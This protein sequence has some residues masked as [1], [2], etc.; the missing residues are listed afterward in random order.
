MA[1]P[2]F[3]SSPSKDLARSDSTP[4]PSQTTGGESPTTLPRTRSTR[5][6]Q[7]SN[8]DTLTVMSRSVS[9]RTSFHHQQQAE[10]SADE[11]TPIVS[12]ER[13][14][15]KNKNYDATSTG[16]SGV[17][18]EAHTS[19]QSSSSSARRRKARPGSS[20]RDNPSG[21]EGKK[22]GGWGWNDLVEKYGSVELENKGSVARDH[23]ALGSSR[24]FLSVFQKGPLS[25]CP[26]IPGQSLGGLKH[27]D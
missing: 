14:G 5:S 13:G 15:A 27:T 8:P 7:F 11:I 22:G 19:R 10:S 24:V 18:G 23:L 17:N 9:P 3:S 1:A 12:K 20:R 21:D 26:S 25:R 4:K 6:V 2:P 16:Q